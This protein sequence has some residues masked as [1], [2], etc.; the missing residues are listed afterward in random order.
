MAARKEAMMNSVRSE[1]ALANAQE[2]MN[3]CEC[4]TDEITASLLAVTSRKQTRNVSSNASPSRA[5]RCHHRNRHA[6][7]NFPIDVLLIPCTAKT[8]L[9]NCWGRYME[10]CECLRFADV[11]WELIINWWDTVDIVSRKYKERMSKELLAT[12]GL[13]LPS[14]DETMK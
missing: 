12:S 8:C 7:L 10:A 6:S 11:R 3:V 5:L 4:D 13:G 14:S 2:L 1:L 9:T